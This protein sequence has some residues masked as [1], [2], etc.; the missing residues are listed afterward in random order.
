MKIYNLG[1]NKSIPNMSRL[2]SANVMH[3]ITNVAHAHMTCQMLAHILS[4]S[5]NREIPCS[6]GILL[7]ADAGKE[8]AKDRRPNGTE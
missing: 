1:A 3:S 4:H 8:S 7:S 6:V 5:R 2:T